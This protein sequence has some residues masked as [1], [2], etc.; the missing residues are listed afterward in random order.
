MQVR[1]WAT[2]TLAVAATVLALVATPVLAN[3][4]VRKSFDRQVVG[5]DTVLIAEGR[6]D[7]GD[8]D[9]A[10]RAERGA[11]C[12]TLRVLNVLKGVAEAEIA[13]EIEGSIAELHLDC[14]EV[15][16][17]YAMALDRGSNG[18]YRSTNAFWSVYELPGPW[19]AA[20]VG[21][22]VNHPA[23]RRPR[24]FD[25]IVVSADVFA[26]V[27]GTGERRSCGNAYVRQDCSVATVIK[28]MKG[29]VSTVMM[30]PLSQRVHDM[31]TGR[32]HDEPFG[33]CEQ[34]QIYALASYEGRN[35]V[36]TPVNS[37]RGSVVRLGA[38][39][40]ALAAGSR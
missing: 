32:S 36:F 38:A 34:G 9:L 17:V 7:R 16:K 13:L 25:Q 29:E 18:A 40:D 23:D 11:T 21:E 3:Y 37:G 39:G 24:S 35:G 22:P 26:I 1:R 12:T 5:A 19:L 15:G 14:C 4:V 6:G 28:A 20:Q 2:I 31:D 27:L 10:H 30:V 33:C 8:C